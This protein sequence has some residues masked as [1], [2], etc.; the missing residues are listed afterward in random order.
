MGS[1]R[2]NPLKETRRSWPAVYVQKSTVLNADWLCA[3]TDVCSIQ[4]PFGKKW[5]KQTHGEFR[6][7]VRYAHVESKQRFTAFA[8]PGRRL[9]VDLEIK[10]R[11]GK[12]QL[13]EQH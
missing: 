2:R 3:L 1:T 7:T 11:K 8:Q 13:Y 4:V 9:R 12:G 5:P 10:P 6:K